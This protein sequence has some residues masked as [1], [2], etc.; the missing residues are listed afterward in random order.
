MPK[1]GFCDKNFEMNSDLTELKIHILKFFEYLILI[2]ASLLCAF[3]VIC[4]RE[5]GA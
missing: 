5:N 3:A 2:D 4:N 1:C